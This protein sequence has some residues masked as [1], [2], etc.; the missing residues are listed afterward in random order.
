M[1]ADNLADRGYANLAFSAFQLVAEVD[2]DASFQARYATLARKLP[3]WVRQHGLGQTVAA[4]Y[5][6]GKGTRYEGADGLLLQPVAALLE[7]GPGTDPRPWVL[8]QPHDRY[9]LA[10]R[11][12]LRASTWLKRFAEARFGVEEGR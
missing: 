8:G 3:T 10:T 11:R 1:S 7:L 6:K 4:L 2:G 5:A 12:L 9:R